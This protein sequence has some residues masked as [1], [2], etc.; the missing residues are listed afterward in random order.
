MKERE[1]YE[2]N[3]SEWMRDEWIWARIW[4]NECVSVI[5]GWVRGEWERRRRV[6]EDEWRY[7]NEDIIIIRNK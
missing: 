2:W 6:R 3:V 1:W 7:E 5:R 4:E